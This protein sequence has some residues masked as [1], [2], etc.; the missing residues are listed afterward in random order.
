MLT[1][2]QSYIYIVIIYRMIV[3]LFAIKIYF[4]PKFISIKNVA[5]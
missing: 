2:L 3:Q 1:R 4:P 5:N